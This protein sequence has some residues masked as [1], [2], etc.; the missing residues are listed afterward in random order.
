[1]FVDVVSG[2]S[3][4]D[5]INGALICTASES[6]INTYYVDGKLTEKGCSFIKDLITKGHESVLEHAVYVFKIENMSRSL[7]QQFARHRHTS[8]SVQSTRWALKR[9]MNNN[10]D[11]NDLVY[12]P[13]PFEYNLN[14][15][16]RVVFD[17][18]VNAQKN[19]WN[20]LY[21]AMDM[22]LPND[23]IKYFITEN[24]YTDMQVTMN[25]R[26]FIHIY[27]LRSKPPAMRE[28]NDLCE[29]ML[30]ALRIF[31]SNLNGILDHITMI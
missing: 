1:M 16:Q 11:F 21:K 15:E 18:L 8:P 22:N 31:D 24:M 20:T 19:Y 17:E 3:V 14:D 7:L 10:S 9:V 13:D 4:K 23:V 30:D 28:F 27:M 12:I 26:E 2:T 29:T 25:L 5:I 6:K